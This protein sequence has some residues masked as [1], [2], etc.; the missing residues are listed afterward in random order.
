MSE[1]TGLTNDQIL[2]LWDAG[3]RM[4]MPGE[5][6][7]F[8]VNVRRGSVEHLLGPL[9]D[10]VIHP[11]QNMPG[12]LRLKRVDGLLGMPCNEKNSPPTKTTLA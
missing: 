5:K 11:E 1:A 12:Y 6:P 8:Y 4:T 3:V 7:D 9:A 2:R 10:D